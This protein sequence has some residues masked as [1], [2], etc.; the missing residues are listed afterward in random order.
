MPAGHPHPGKLDALH[1]VLLRRRQRSGAAREEANAAR[2][3]SGPAQQVS[4]IGRHGLAADSGALLS[5]RGNLPGRRG[6]VFGTVP[7]DQSGQKKRLLAGYWIATGGLPL[8]F[9]VT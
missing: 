8:S 7:L 3:Q 9:L 2:R 6:E 5:P 1:R 4:V